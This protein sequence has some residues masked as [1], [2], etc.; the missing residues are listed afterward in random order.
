MQIMQGLALVVS[1][2][3]AAQRRAGLT[4][5]MAPIIEQLQATLQQ[6]RP[7]SANGALNGG[8]AGS[9][10]AQ[11][12]SS[13]DLTLVERLTTLFRSESHHSLC[14]EETLRLAL[15]VS[16]WCICHWAWPHAK[17]ERPPLGAQ[18]AFS[19][20]LVDRVRTAD[21]T[22]LSTVQ[23]AIAQLLGWFL[24][25]ACLESIRHPAMLTLICH[26]C[27]RFVEDPDAMAQAL[28]QVWP[29]LE[30]GFTRHKG[31]VRAIERYARCPR[32]ALRG[33][34]TLSPHPKCSLTIPID[35]A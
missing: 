27:A 1:G 23:G 20:A 8:S 22:R 10:H 32:Y 3:P 6:G 33:A 5:L 7:L 17:P 9:P 24:T 29:L 30:K 2:L 15:P 28:Q 4:A 26:A 13:L 14:L 34:G 25:G 12:S 35:V 21:L 31:N 16:V 18:R 11:S 19:R